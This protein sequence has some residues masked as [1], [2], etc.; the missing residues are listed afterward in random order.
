MW[1]IILIIIIG[2]FSI[3]ATAFVPKLRRFHEHTNSSIKRLFMN[4]GSSTL[5]NKALQNIYDEMIKLSIND[6]E[7]LHSKEP[8]KCPEIIKCLDIMNNVSLDEIG[9]TDDKIDILDNIDSPMC[10]MITGNNAFHISVFILPPNQSLPL[11]DHPNMSV[12]SKILRGSMKIKA[13]SKSN[14]QNNNYIVSVDEIRN[15]NTPAWCL[16]P[17]DSNI[18]EFTSLGGDNNNNESCVILDLLLPPYLEGRRDCTYYNSEVSNDDKWKLKAIK[19]EPNVPLPK[20]FQ[21]FGYQV[22][23]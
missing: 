17:T 14:L 2:L 12:L 5:Q 19:G 18:H 10:T 8:L 23:T 3:V 9:F 20:G 16:T 4:M 11:H 7:N 21:Y 13:F 1:V 6:I 15:M 22:K